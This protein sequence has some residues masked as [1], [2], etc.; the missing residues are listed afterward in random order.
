MRRCAVVLVVGFGLGCSGAGEPASQSFGGASSSSGGIG[1]GSGGASGSP[2]SGGGET[3]GTGGSFGGSGGLPDAA[4]PT[5]GGPPDPVP[6]VDGPPEVSCTIRVID[7][8]GLSAA[9]DALS[10]GDTVCLASGEW[11]DLSIEV[12]AVGTATAPITVAAERPGEVVLTGDVSIA[13]G[14]EHIIVTGLILRDGRT[15]GPHLIDFRATSGECKNCRLSNVA[16]VQLADTGDTKWVSLRGEDNRVDHSAFIGKSNDG[17]L[18]VVW[19]P[20]SLPDRHRI[21]HNYFAER[22]ALGRNGGETMRI[23]DSSQHESDSFTVVEDNY[24][25]RSNGEVE[26]ISNKSS[27]NTYR[28][29][30]FVESEGLLTLRHGNDC[31]VESNVFLVGGVNGGGIRVV[32]SG[33]RIV[34][35]YV[36]GCRTTSNVR[37]GIVLMLADPSPAANGYQQVENV[38]VFHNTIVDCQQSFL[39]GGGRAEVTPR[40]VALRANVVALGLAGGSAVREVKPMDGTVSSNNIFFGGDLGAADSTGF[41]LEDPG[42]VP[43]AGGVMRPTASSPVLDR[44]PQ[45]DVLADMDGDPRDSMADLGADEFSM[46]PS[47]LPITREQVGPRYDFETLP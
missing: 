14:G 6:P 4:P 17:A 20:D 11:A 5:D 9:L 41:A 10:P 31:T 42:L 2:G 25:F 38:E 15:A 39:F 45:G 24:F 35:N 36:E 32:G 13:M 33:H 46:N 44:V 1:G 40:Q 16:V 43:G 22:P 3:A 19:R 26:I 21:D 12:D 28:R 30:V 37:G 7:P 23:G 47:R 34:N 18:L 8:P 29:N 27:S